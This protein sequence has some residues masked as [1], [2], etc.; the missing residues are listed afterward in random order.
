MHVAQKSWSRFELDLDFCT[1]F[2]SSTA[3]EWFR[4]GDTFSKLHTLT[5][6]ISY[7]IIYPSVIAQYS[8][9]DALIMITTAPRG[10]P[11]DNICKHI[12]VW[13]YW[14]WTHNLAE[15]KRIMSSIQMQIE[16]HSIIFHYSYRYK[17][18]YI[19]RQQCCRF[20]CKIFQWSLCY[21]LGETKQTLHGIWIAPNNCEIG[22]GALLI[23]VGVILSILPMFNEATWRI[24]AW[25]NYITIGSDNGMSPHDTKPLP[26]PIYILTNHQ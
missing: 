3:H 24:Y 11:R 22:N 23:W 13:M 15:V 12:W 18:L 16:R 1:Q 2:K 26:E 10:K 5:W 4:N 25:V 14:V 8:W 21:N 19:P 7:C 9:V 6:L 17:C 20:I